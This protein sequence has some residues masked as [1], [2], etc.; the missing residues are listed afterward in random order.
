MPEYQVK[1]VTVLEPRKSWRTPSYGELWKTAEES[2]P[3]LLGCPACGLA[4]SLRHDVVFIDGKPTITPSV[5]CP[6][7]GCGAHYF[8]VNGEVQ[9][10]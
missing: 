8:V 9:P 1:R 6:G 4:A 2:E 10:C 3:W 7:P 5:V